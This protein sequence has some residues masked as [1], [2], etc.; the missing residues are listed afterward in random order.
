MTEKAAALAVPAIIC[1][2]AVL[3][4]FGRRP[5]FD[6]FVEGAKDGLKTA[7]GLL[8]TLV[9]LLVAVK[10]L[11]ASGIIESL[12]ALVA[13]AAQ[14][15]GIPEGLLPLLLTR[16][17]SGSAST[18]MY[19]ELLAKYGADSLSG[20][21]ASV[22]MGSSDTLIYVLGVYFSSVGIK[23]SGYAMPCAVIVMLFCIFFSCFI[24]RLCFF[25]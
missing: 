5:Y 4:L 17:V 19:S 18:A 20:M 21:C 11:N 9:L 3:S 14:K 13:P 25:T 1:V 2:M 22:I 23:K 15:L 16:P 10:M 12:S 8:P 24:C 7:I 6:Y